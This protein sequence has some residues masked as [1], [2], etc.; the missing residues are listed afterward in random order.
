MSR[1]SI[2]EPHSR[3]EPTAYRD[4]GPTIATNVTPPT[5]TWQSLE[6]EALHKKLYTTSEVKKR[7]WPDV[8]EEEIAEIANS[9]NDAYSRGYKDA[10]GEG[11]S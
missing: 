9:L 11:A 4:P 3:D 6:A 2:T 7:N 1:Q 5:T 8:Y 10:S